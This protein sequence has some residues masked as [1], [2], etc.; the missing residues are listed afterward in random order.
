MLRSAGHQ[1]NNNWWVS[2]TI[3][4]NRQDWRTSAEGLPDDSRCRVI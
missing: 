4:G 3:L 2:V 1:V